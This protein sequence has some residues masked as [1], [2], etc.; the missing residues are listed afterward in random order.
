MDKYIGHPVGSSENPL[1]DTQIEEKFTNLASAVLDP[2]ATRA[3]IDAVWSIENS[4]DLTA[5][6]AK[7]VGH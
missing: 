4:T 3:A 7:F 1:S 2:A 5:F 6:A